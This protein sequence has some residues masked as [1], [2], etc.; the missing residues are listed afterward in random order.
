MRSKLWLLVAFSVLILTTIGCED[1]TGPT[2]PPTTAG[3]GFFIS[4]FTSFN[5][6]PPVVSP[7]A[8]INGNWLSDGV[9]AMGDASPWSVTTNTAGVGIV[10]NGRAPADWNFTW[11]FALTPGCG[12]QSAKGTVHFRDEDITVLCV[13]IQSTGFSSVSTNSDFAFAPNPVLTSAPA[14]PGTITGSGIDPTYGMPLV[15]YYALDGTLAAQQNATS[16]SSDGTSLQIPGRDMSQLPGG[17]YVGFINNANPDGTFSPVGGVSV[18]VADASVMIDGSE[19][20]YIDY[21]GCEYIGSKPTHCPTYYDSGSVIVNVNGYN[22]TASYG[23]SSTPETVAND[24]ANV[25]NGDPASPVVASLQGSMLL[26]SCKT[27]GVGSGYGL[28]TTVNY[29]GIDFS[30]A[31]FIATPSGPTL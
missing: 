1:N 7:L 16:V 27:A 4:T 3:G 5:L 9:N 19:Q 24:L 25:F 29:D 15:Q 12:G 8:V 31:S 11:N 23:R 22:A 28:T 26:L 18:E 30:G 17:T 14:S 13:I 21:S 10:N 2:L 20:S 6:T